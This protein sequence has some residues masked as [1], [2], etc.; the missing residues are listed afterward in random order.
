MRTCL[1]PLILYHHSLSVY[2]ISQKKTRPTNP[3]GNSSAS[4]L[5][6][7]LRRDST[8]Q[9]T[10]APSRSAL[11]EPEQQYAANE[12]NNE[13]GISYQFGSFADGADPREARSE[14]AQDV[15]LETL[16]SL[17]WSSFRT[18]HPSSRSADMQQ[19]QVFTGSAR[20]A[21]PQSFAL[22]RR[23]ATPTPSRQ[24]ATPQAPRQFG[25]YPVQ[26]SAREV[27]VVRTIC[28]RISG[29]ILCITD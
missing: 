20:S 6:T 29:N 4:Q 14:A 15:S 18:A 26:P 25:T 2:R 27:L 11:L 28:E 23:T 3:T 17:S 12:V 16:P 8:T 7:G 1:S 13:G 5:Y 24:T 9:P 19:R 21:T 22:Q 10:R